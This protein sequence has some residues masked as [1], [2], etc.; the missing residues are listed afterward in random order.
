MAAAVAAVA[1]PDQEVAQFRVWKARG[2][3]A[4]ISQFPSAGEQAVRPSPVVVPNGLSL[5]GIA[6]KS[7][8]EMSPFI[9]VPR[10]DSRIADCQPISCSTVKLYCWIRGCWRSKVPSF[11]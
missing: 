10:Y 1:E 11:R 9:F 3:A 7:R 6:L 2:S 5:G 8:P 4:E